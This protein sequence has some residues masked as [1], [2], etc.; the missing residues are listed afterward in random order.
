MIIFMLIDVLFNN[1]ARMSESMAS[2]IQMTSESLIDKK[3]GGG[4][5]PR[6][7]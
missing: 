7:T 3:V 4:G 5:K 1:T 6:G 2:D